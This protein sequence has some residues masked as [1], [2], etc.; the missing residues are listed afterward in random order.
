VLLALAVGGVIPVGGLAIVFF[1]MFSS[2]RQ[3]LNRLTVI[4]G[5]TVI[6]LMS[7]TAC[8]LSN[9]TE[10]STP[11]QAAASPSPSLTPTC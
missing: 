10:Q 4:A 9:Q 11:N 6:T 3:E 8:T 7:L 5:L 1:P 2:R